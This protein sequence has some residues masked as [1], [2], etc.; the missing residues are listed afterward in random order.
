MPEHDN[1]ANQASSARDSDERQLVVFRLSE[2]EFG[3]EID[4]VKEIVRLPDL[5]PVPRAPDYIAG[6][7]NLRG[8]VLPVIDTRVRFSMEARKDT[9]HTRLLVVETQGGVHSGLIV[10]SMRE[11]MRL[12]YARVEAPP[13]VCKGVDREFLTGVVKMDDGKRLILILNLNE[14]LFADNET[15]TDKQHESSSFRKQ[16]LGTGKEEKISEEYLVSFWVANDEYAFDISKVREIIKISGM[17]A[18]PNVPGYV[19]GLFTIRN[20]LMPIIDLR[21]LLGL[22]SLI[23]ER[24]AMIDKAVKEHQTWADRLLH[25][26]KSGAHFTGTLKAKETVFGKWL[27]NYNT[28]GTEVEQVVRTL[29]RAR[30]ELFGYAAAAS[31]ADKKE[32]KIALF[33]ENVAPKLLI[34]SDIFS[35]LREV[36][37]RNIL[38]DQRALVIESKNMTIGY[39]VD[40]VDE[41]LRIPKN[42]IDETPLMA[43]SERKEIKAVA[44]LDQGERLIMIMDESALTSSEASEIVSDMNI[45]SDAG[46]TLAQESMDEEQVVTF[47]IN[48]EEYAIRIMQVQEINRIT[49]ITAVPKAPYC[50]EG[51]TNLRG[52]VIPVLNIRRLFGLE[53]R[54]ADDQTRIIFCSMDGNKTG[55]LVDQ[56]SE[57][58]RLSRQNIIQTPQIVTS[59]SNQYM[60]AIC[61]IDDGKRL[62]ILLDLKKILD[63]E[64]LK[65]VTGVTKNPEPKEPQTS[66]AVKEKAKPDKKAVKKKK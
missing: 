15:L 2:E 1:T 35:E 47:T 45:E 11:V 44:R 12:N 16:E 55:I 24:H 19:K 50:I 26:L 61:K 65:N 34:I 57:V 46:K 63:K 29:K 31:E 30:T 53:D 17:T 59:E 66:V 8:N 56:V 54:K 9:E 38:E 22:P 28:S 21:E 5:T 7:C 48:T 40:R 58:L 20:Q 49:D 3:L 10:D 6:I 52:Q 23:S 27:E 60:E 41:V 64:E 42:V 43:R 36:M 33:E 39:L 51:M 18:I 25:V 4:K 62:A 37:T 14:V 32:R 13:A